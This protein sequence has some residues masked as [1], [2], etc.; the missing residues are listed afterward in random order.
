MAS[1]DGL[2]GLD[3][4]YFIVATISTVGFGDFAPV[5]QGARAAALLFMPLGLVIIGFGISYATASNRARPNQIAQ[6]NGAMGGMGGMG[7]ADRNRTRS[8]FNVLSPLRMLVAT[9]H[10]A[11]AALSSSGKSGSSAA[12]AQAAGALAAQH[13]ADG[14]GDKAILMGEKTPLFLALLE[15]APGAAEAAWARVFAGSAA[16][17]AAWLTVKLASVVLV[18]AGFFKLYVPEKDALPLTWVDACYFAM[19]CA[20]S[21]G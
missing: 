21:I 2:T 17:K 6:S 4:W 16:G 10:E 20:T 15:R 14:D 18:G 3:C 5:S 11:N 9:K 19:V 1:L 13:L 8:M 12:A 7:G